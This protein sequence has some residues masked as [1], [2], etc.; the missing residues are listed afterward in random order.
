MTGDSFRIAAVEI[1]AEQRIPE[2]GE[3][4]TDLVGTSRFE[5]QSQKGMFSVRPHHFIMCARGLSIGRD[6]A[7][8]DAR[9]G[10]C[11]RRIDRA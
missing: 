11:N 9:Q 4:D 8:D 3:V 2:V 1:I 10:A 6:M 5:A 7:Q